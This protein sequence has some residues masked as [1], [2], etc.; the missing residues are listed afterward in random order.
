M[1]KVFIGLLIGIGIGGAGAY[2]YS[3]AM[4]TEKLKVVATERDTKSQELTACTEQKVKIENDLKEADA[5]LKVN[6]SL[7]CFVSSAILGAPQFTPADLDVIHSDNTGN[8]VINWEPIKGAKKY[9]VRVES[10]DGTLVNT[11]EVEGEPTMSLDRVTKA[12]KLGAA[13]YYVRI[14]AVNGLDQ[15][16]A[17]SERKPIQFS[18]VSFK[19]NPSKKAKIKSKKR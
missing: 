12:S 11:T 15:E 14:T 10:E 7:S 5:E 8:V 13:Q 6:E 17:Q 16:G 1:F 9:I 4:F 19:A 18:S 3:E 2:Y